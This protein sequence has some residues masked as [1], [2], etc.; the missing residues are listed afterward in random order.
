MKYLT[1]VLLTAFCSIQAFAQT[2]PPPGMADIARDKSIAGA[3]NSAESFALDWGFVDQLRQRWDSFDGQVREAAKRQQGVLF[4]VGVQHFTDTNERR[5]QVF[6]P[7][8]TGKDFKS[9]LTI[10]LITNPDGELRAGDGNGYRYVYAY[11]FAVVDKDGNI[12]RVFATDE[13]YKSAR[14][15]AVNAKEIQNIRRERVKEQQG[16]RKREKERWEAHLRYEQQIRDIEA[17]RN[18][19][20]DFYAT[21]PGPATPSATPSGM[22]EK[23]PADLMDTNKLTWLTPS[24]TPPPAPYRDSEVIKIRPHVEAPVIQVKP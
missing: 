19:W 1:S 23:R 18:F 15:E 10:Y 8:A 6:T 2:T 16:V 12:Q 22:V 14:Q 3:I 13:M 24:Y 20:R 17:L 21:M 11:G 9:A 4:F 7:I 5:V